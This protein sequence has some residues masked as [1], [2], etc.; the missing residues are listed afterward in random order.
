MLEQYGKQA[1]LDPLLKPHTKGNSKWFL[2]VKYEA[3]VDHMEG[4]L[5]NLRNHS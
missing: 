3:G 5:Y 1:L 2:N 4:L